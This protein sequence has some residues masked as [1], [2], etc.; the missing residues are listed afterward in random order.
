MGHSL[1]DVDFPYFV[2]VIR[3]I[4]GSRVTWKISYY[5]DLEASQ[6]RFFK[7]GISSA[8]VEFARLPE[9]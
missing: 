6:C 3:N 7:L 2:E 1:A 9:F 5:N 4:D 8:L